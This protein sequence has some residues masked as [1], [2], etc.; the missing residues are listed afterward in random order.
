M[1]FGNDD[2]KTDRINDLLALIDKRL[3]GERAAPAKVFVGGY[4]EHVAWH[5]IAGMELDEMYGSALSLWQFA[6]GH[7]PGDTLIRVYNPRFEEQGW[8]ADH[9]IVEV[10]TDD[11]PFLVDSGTVMLQAKDLNVH[12]V[13][14]P[15]IKVR[16][17]KDGTIAELL[18][19]DAEGKDVTAVS[20]MHFEVNEQT[21]PAVL[22]GLEASL[23]DVYGDVRAAVED[24]PQMRQ[25]ATAQIEA[26]RKAKNL[27]TEP[28]EVAEAA[29]FLQWLHDDHFIFL[30]YRDYAYPSKGRKGG[31]DPES[32]LGVLRDPDRILMRQL[33]GDGNMP[34]DVSRFFSS[35]EMLMVT[36]AEG[37]SYVHRAARLDVIGVKQFDKSGKAIG[38]RLFAGLFTSVAYNRSPSDIPMLRRRVSTILG[39]AGLRPSSHDGKALVNILETY[40]RDEL[41]QADI[42]TLFETSIGILQLQERQRVALFL[43]RDSFERFV[44]C[45]VFVPRDNYTTDLRKRIN[46]ILAKA[47]NGEVTVFYTQIGDSMLARLHVI[48]KTEPG[49][50]PDY[51]VHEIEES[52]VEAART[53]TDR[54]TEALVNDRGEEAGLKLA[55]RY[56]GAFPAGYS[57]KV[58]AHAAV[59]DLEKIEAAIAAAGIE[60]NLYRPIEARPDEI[61]FKLYHPDGAVPL[62]FVMPMLENMGLRV[63]D[64]EPTEVRPADAGKVMIHDFGLVTRDGSAV[65]LAAVREKFHTAFRAL[66]N[67]EI[68][69]DGFNRLVLAGIDPRDI[70]ILRAYA[71]FLRQ[72][73]I[74]YSQSYMEDTLGNHAPI[75]RL[76]IDLFRAR[77]DPAAE[78]D[79][80]KTCDGLVKQIVGELNDVTNADED[81]MLG[82]FLNCITSTLRTNYFQRG[83]D[84]G[85]KPALSL[86][87]NSHNLMELP[88]PAPLREIFVYSPRLEAV[89]LRF[90]LVARGGLRWS[91]RREDFRTEILGL[92]KAQQVKNAVIVP[93]GSKGG[94][95]LKKPPQEGGREAFLEEGVACYKTFLRSML[96]ITDNLVGGEVVPPVDVVRWD[97][98]DP[99]LVVAADK[100]TATFS[101]YANSVSA[102]YGF[103]LDDAYASG[104]SQGYDHKKMGITAR[105]AWESVKRHFREMGINCQTEPFTCVGVGDMAGDVFGN[106][107]LNS[108][109]TKLVG[110]FNHMHIFID[111]DPDIA[112]S[113]AERKRMFDLPR[114]SWTDYNTKLI[115]KGGGIFERSAKTIKLSP[116]IRKLFEIEETELPPNELIRHMLKAEVDLLWFGGIGTYIKESG[117][118]NSDA[119]DRANDSLRINGADVRAKVIGEGANLGATQLGR[120]EA[121]MNGVRLNTDSIDN[122]A[123]VDC[124]DHEVNIKILLG[125]VVAD[126]DMTMKQRNKLLVEMTE[127][128]GDLVLRDNYLQSQAISLVE[129]GGAATLHPQRQL[130]RMLERMGRLNRSI[131]YLPDDEEIQ[132]RQA[133]HI[134]LTRPEISILMPYAKI[135]L[136]D[137]LL[138]SDLPDD[139]QLEEDLVRYFPTALRK[140]FRA[141]IGQHRLRREIITTVVTNSMINRVGGWFAAEIGERTGM[142]PVDIARAYTITRDVFA[143]REVWMEIEALDNKVSADLQ[144]S[145]LGWINK[146]I[147]GGV[148]WF[149]RNGP[150]PLDISS[151]L[152]TYASGVAEIAGAL[153][154]LVVGDVKEILNR[155]AEKMIAEK[156]PPALAHKVANTS[157]MVTAIDICRIA[158]S[159]GKKVTDVGALYFKVGDRFGLDWVRLASDRAEG[160]THWERLAVSAIVEDFYSHQSAITAAIL[161]SS[162]GKTTDAAIDAWVETNRVAVDRTAQLVGEFQS[163]QGDVD[164]AMLAVANRQFRSMS[165]Q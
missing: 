113:Y 68:E 156:V 109:A 115:S 45:L 142:S 72:A 18:G 34:E 128:V 145:M 132:E 25:A 129:Q 54:L 21:D 3:G 33:R 56:G 121:A 118:S 153:D 164:L 94:F 92:V 75:A 139:P 99:Y 64:E 48:V 106:G 138:G 19:E 122:S 66:W 102:E 52:L 17:A 57:E 105:G 62:S 143:L 23:E 5:D 126:G 90:G 95:V 97:D 111:P 100:G 134:G 69:N 15:I 110:A 125:G 160:D 141:Q 120:I 14:H 9:T 41:F 13:I 30:G 144:L 49:S 6:Q 146:L 157:I 38:Q 50:V 42:G 73:S 161:H 152:K 35:S 85:P 67:E 60:M 10:V 71:K 123:G 80:K 31:V 43:R 55:Q 84:G 163:M 162:N 149:L 82:R 37:P 16:R 7:K 58:N 159:S 119:G 27:P 155:R 101:D 93:V 4:Y 63:I 24:W 130:M 147:T 61:R 165:E 12:L 65:D 8:K 39:R 104:G 135:W 98:D 1:A 78:G 77:F 70:T 91:D 131:E 89:H 148:L 150:H 88:L 36:K 96:D 53:W 2:R 107:M 76:L 26:L 51:D 86:K 46:A 87:F 103:W 124:S 59:F 116:E 79:R 137:E 20:C 22:A 154:K 32:G 108:E 136:Y 140:K 127:E 158:A 29:D 74:T 117:E 28:D 47:L 151:N 133:R 81:R 11:M 40:P 83:A 44:S 112:K 114:S